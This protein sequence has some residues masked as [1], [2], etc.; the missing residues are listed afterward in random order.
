MTGRGKHP[1]KGR[2]R[3]PCLG[4]LVA[5]LLSHATMAQTDI[6]AWR[7]DGE[8]AEVDA[9][10]AAIDRFNAA[11]SKWRVSVELLPQ[12]SYAQS[13]TAAALAGRL[14]CIL[15][16]DQPLVPSFAW[17]GHLRPLD[18]L[19]DPDLVSSLLPTA[20]GT[21]RGQLY[22]VGQFDA[23]LA[24]FARRSAL[25]AVGARYPTIDA[26]WSKAEFA[27]ILKDLKARDPDAYPLDLQ[28]GEQGEWWSYAFSPFLQSFG[29]D[30]I[31]RETMLTAE[32][33]LNG[34][35][36]A[37]WATWF[38]GLFAAG[39]VNPRPPDQKG[40]TLG[41]NVMAYGGNW[42]ANEFLAAWGDDVVILP[43]VDF[44]EG[45]VIG[46]GSWQWGIT[47]TCTHTEGANAF[48]EFLMQDEEIAAMAKATG[49]IPVSDAAA[50]LH[51]DYGVGGERRIF[52][53]F[54][55]EFARKR[56]ATPAYPFISSIFEREVRNI[57]DGKMPLDALDDA[58][59][60]INRNIS[61]NKGYGFTRGAAQI[62]G[63]H[64]A[65]EGRHGDR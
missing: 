19:I 12:N 40:F 62:S 5:A 48:I 1:A 63:A 15:E 27:A 18:G 9:S 30:L 2:R 59:D 43:P 60:S 28:A 54:S 36:A 46:G 50:A 37:R 22:S 14:P 4:G 16:V 26:P 57:R 52:Y 39:Y 6:M 51:P 29:G 33:T 11:Q 53:E 17:A 65:A 13:I 64:T 49:L 8:Q 10:L 45:P 31:D 47:A 35:A 7:H 58:V 24:I 56:P 42:S 41:R 3:L 38:Q 23:V 44:G 32:G 20:L 55:K 21:Y 34:D 61:D 25:E